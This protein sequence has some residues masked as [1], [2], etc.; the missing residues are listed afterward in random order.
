[1]KRKYY[2]FSKTELATNKGVIGCTFK[3]TPEDGSPPDSDLFLSV[4]ADD[5]A[6]L[7][8]DTFYE[9]HML[10]VQVEQAG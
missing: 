10:P 5:A 9:M 4:A 2:L 7:T 3:S 6:A 1:M 8:V